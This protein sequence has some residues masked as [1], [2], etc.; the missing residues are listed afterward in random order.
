MWPAAMVWFECCVFS[1]GKGNCP[2]CG[3]EAVKWFFQS[4]CYHLSFM[5]GSMKCGL[6]Q[7]WGG[8]LS[9][10]CCICVS[11]C[12]AC[13][14]FRGAW[15]DIPGALLLESLWLSLSVAWSCWGRWSTIP[16]WSQYPECSD[17]SN[18]HIHGSRYNLLLKATISPLSLCHVR[19]ELCFS[20]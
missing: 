12:W 20:I 9:H 3:L 5:R 17:Y 19:K 16:C 6:L 1:W 8:K 10:A 7:C 2:L 13:S 4:N 11:C 14:F 15:R 18:G